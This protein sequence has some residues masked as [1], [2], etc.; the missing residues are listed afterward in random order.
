MEIPKQLQNPEFRFCLVNK[1]NAKN[2]EGKPI[3]KAPFETAWQKKGY[4]FDDPKLIAHIKA[5]GNYG[6]IGGYGKLVIV[7]I[8][9]VELG[10]ELEKKFQTF[11]VKTGGGGR[12]FYFIEDEE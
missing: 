5:G 4:K 11:T 7:D 2:K 1:W 10:E 6:V 9:D 8:D 12:H 3:G